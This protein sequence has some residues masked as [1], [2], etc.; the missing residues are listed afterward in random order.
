MSPPYSSFSYYHCCCSVFIVPFY[1]TLSYYPSADLS[2]CSLLLFLLFVFP[3]ALPYPPLLCFILLPL[4]LLY[5]LTHLTLPYRITLAAALSCS[6]YSSCPQFS[7]LYF[8]NSCCSAL[9]PFT[10]L[11][12]IIPAASLSS[13]SLYS[14][15]SYYPCCF[16]V[17]L[18]PLLFFILLPLL[19]LCI[20]VLFSSSFS[21]YSLLLCIVL[22]YSSF[23]YYPCCYLYSCSLYFSL[24]YYPCCCFVFLFPLL[25]FILLPLLL[26]C[27]FV[28]HLLFYL[29]V[30]PAALPCYNLLFFILLSLLLLSLLVPLY[31][32]LLCI[33]CCSALFPITLLHHITLADA[34]SSC[35]PL[36]LFI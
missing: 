5:L 1:S 22:L 20:L 24:S 17:F 6:P 14:S 11:S 32:F 16:S 33:P 21:L 18:F 23:S 3:A 35:S 12:L 34:L 19:L 15:F 30:F 9:F 8:C 28:P 27:L 4:L 2:T 13:T 26:L 36:L 29:F 10:I 25:F 31:S 7:L